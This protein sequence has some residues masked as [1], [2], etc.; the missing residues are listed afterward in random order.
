[1]AGGI[2]AC[3][4][5]PNVYVG[6]RLL[7]RKKRTNF[8]SLS[9]CIYLIFSFLYRG[10]GTFVLKMIIRNILAKYRKESLSLF[11]SLA[12]QNRYKEF[13]WSEGMYVCV[14]MC[15]N[16]IFLSLVRHAAGL[17]FVALSFYWSFCS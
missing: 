12:L 7:P 3:W 2:R 6:R 4:S 11:L 8:L 15:K 14:C 9:V 17:E 13:F 10:S 1:M 5:W 16:S